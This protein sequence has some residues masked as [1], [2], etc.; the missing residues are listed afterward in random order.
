M[1]RDTTGQARGWVTVHDRAAGRVLTDLVVDPTLDASRADP[2]AAALLDWAARA[3]AALGDRRGVETTQLDAGAH[4]SDRR[5]QRWLTAAGFRHVRSWW[6]MTRPVDRSEA[7]PGVLPPPRPGVRIRTVADDE[8]QR[9]PDDDLRAVHDI[10]EAAFAD[11]FN[12]HEESFEEF[13]GRL[14]EDPGHAW[15]HWW[16]AEVERGGEGARPAG[17]LIAQ[18]IRGDDGRAK[19]SYV[20]YLGVLR[21]ARGMGVARS[22]LH[23]VVADAAARGRDVV[24]LEVD[25]D[26]PTG[27]AE[28][29]SSMGFVSRYTTQ[30]WHRDVRAG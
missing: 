2:L 30:S 18:E 8:H 21:T 14:R 25:A 26:S 10:L 22:L 11:H 9:P 29:Y 17:A 4:E 15:D 24:K 13:L 27:A 19:G 6:Q 12:Y 23:A 7:D 5:K 20:S 16:L 1:V 3:G 28:L